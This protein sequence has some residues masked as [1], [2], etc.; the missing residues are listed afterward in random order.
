MTAPYVPLRNLSCFTMLEGAMEP[1]TIAERAAMLGFPAIALTDRDGEVVVVL[2]ANGAGKTTTLKA[3]MGLLPK[4]IRVSS[5]AIH[6]DGMNIV[7]MS[8]DKLRSLRGRR[9]PARSWITRFRATRSPRSSSGQSSAGWRSWRLASKATAAS[10]AS[11]KSCSKRLRMWAKPPQID[12]RQ[13]NGYCDVAVP[14]LALIHRPLV[15]AC[16]LTGVFCTLPLNMVHPVKL[17]GVVN[18]P[19]ARPLPFN[20]GF[21]HTMS[22]L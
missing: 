4:A 14:Q 18:V 20:W 5:G 11:M 19:S 16:S 13:E 22:I 8:P 12:E 6:L 21:A 1:K 10:A 15:S 3:I 9:I 17:S 7:G 2:G